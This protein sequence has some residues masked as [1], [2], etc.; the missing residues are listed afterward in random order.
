VPKE[1]EVAYNQLRTTLLKTEQFQFCTS[2]MAMPIE[3]SLFEQVYAR[4]A[5]D[6]LVFDIQHCC[7]CDCNKFY[8]VN[9][10]F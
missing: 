9:I 3:S 2:T 6:P 8:F 5:T 7:D 1:K 10:L 4:S